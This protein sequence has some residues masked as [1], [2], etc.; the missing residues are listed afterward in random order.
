M[1]QLRFSQ[2][3]AAIVSTCLPG[4]IEGTYNFD[5]KT[6][7]MWLKSDAYLSSLDDKAS[8]H[9]KNFISPKLSS[10]YP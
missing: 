8:A 6:A 10:M 3:R 2:M 9:S 7:L 4:K 5:F 1:L